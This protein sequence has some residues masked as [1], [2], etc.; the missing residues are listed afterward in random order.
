MIC[1]GFERHPVKKRFRHTLGLQ[2]AHPIGREPHHIETVR[3]F[4]ELSMVQEPIGLVVTHKVV[5]QLFLMLAVRATGT[6]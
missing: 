4:C 2:L 3:T 1:D 5:D 6:A